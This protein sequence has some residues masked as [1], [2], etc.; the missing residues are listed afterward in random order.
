MPH[1]PKA[2]R[3]NYLPKRASTGNER[4][5][6]TH[7]RNKWKVLSKR[8]RSTRPCEP[9]QFLGHIHEA[10]DVDHIIS[11]PIGAPYDEANLMPMCKQMHGKKS[12]LDKEGFRIPTQQGHD[13]LIPVDRMDIL[14]ALAG[15]DDRNR[16]E[17]KETLWL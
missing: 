11:L 6:D 4:S 1:L 17:E 9:C 16:G 3:P 2:K 13:G 15:F 10:Q 8:L 12:Q 14:T 5:S 7:T